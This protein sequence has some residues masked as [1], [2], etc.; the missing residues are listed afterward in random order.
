MG[1]FNSRGGGGHA[2]SMGMHGSTIPLY[3]AAVGG[4]AH[5]RNN[6]NNHHDVHPPSVKTGKFKDEKII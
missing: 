5:Q 6:N 3:G 1:M 2:S 4:S